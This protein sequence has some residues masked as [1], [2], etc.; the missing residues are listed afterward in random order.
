MRVGV[1]RR[2]VRAGLGVARDDVASS[3]A[4]VMAALMVQRDGRAGLAGRHAVERARAERW[5]HVLR[6][7]DGGDGSILRSTQD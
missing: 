3:H 7:V 4:G 1:G 5:R 6:S 2:R